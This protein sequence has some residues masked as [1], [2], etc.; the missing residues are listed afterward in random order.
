MK[1]KKKKIYSQLKCL[2][3]LLVK[4]GKMQMEMTRRMKLKKQDILVG[5]Y[6]SA[7]RP[8]EPLLIYSDKAGSLLPRLSKPTPL[9]RVARRLSVS[10]VLG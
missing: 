1:K 4:T 2:T 7:A 10:L 6:A 3:S 8:V 5:S 9:T